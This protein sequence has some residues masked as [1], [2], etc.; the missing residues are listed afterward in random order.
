M[1]RFPTPLSTLALLLA[2]A[3]PGQ[4]Q[5][6]AELMAGLRQ[7]GGWIAVPIEEGTGVMRTAAV[8]TLGLVVTGCAQIW[9]G[10]SGTWEIRLRDSV[11][12]RT[13]EVSAA[14]GEPIL[15]TH[16]SAMMSQ[17]DLDV[18]WSEPRD[19]TLVMWIGI[20]TPERKGDKAC[21]PAEYGG[22]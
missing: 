9:G 8:P 18:R 17:V 19:T 5:T 6:A 2:L 15:F 14:P 22:G 16:A 11:S 4:A 1:R 10:H 12:G 3:L 13:L 7:G 21:V 20:E